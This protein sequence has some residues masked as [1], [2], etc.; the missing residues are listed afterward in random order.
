MLRETCLLVPLVA[1]LH[2]RFLVGMSAASAAYSLA[3]LFIIVH[4]AVKKISMVPS[5]R[6]LWLLFAGDQVCQLVILMC[7]FWCDL[8]K[9]CILSVF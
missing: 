6:H 4:R 8:D 9:M 2:F 3:Q 1:V 5:R 7:F